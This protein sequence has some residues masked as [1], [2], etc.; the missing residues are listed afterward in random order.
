M[1][2]KLMTSTLCSAMVLI[3]AAVSAGGFGNRVA[4]EGVVI[5][6]VNTDDD[7]TVAPLIGSLN[8]GLIAGAVVIALVAVASSGGSTSA[9]NG[10]N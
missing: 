3:P 10:T 4:S 6:P 9:T 1:V 7:T 2:K 8:G 5:T